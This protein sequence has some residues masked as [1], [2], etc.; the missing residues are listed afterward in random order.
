MA[1]EIK[2]IVQGD[3]D[4]FR[5][6]YNQY[7][8]AMYNTCLRMLGHEEDAT[9]ALQETFIKVFQNIG[10]LENEALLA[11]WIKR[12]CVNTCLQILEKKKK[13]RWEDIDHSPVLLNLNDESEIVDE[14][15]HELNMRRL[16][17]AIL[18][19]PEKYRVV[20]TMYAVEDYSHEEIGKSLGI[21]TATSR[22]QYMRA[23]Q[24]LYE[25]LKKNEN[26]VRPLEILHPGA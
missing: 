6:L 15:A 14:E 3:Q 2:K 1:V 13:I 9:D 21:A 23:K 10:K 24:K 25:L 19:L 12:I 5:I 26:Y 22:S 11:A 4:A 18:Q 20:L 17:E 8:V 7:S 16:Q